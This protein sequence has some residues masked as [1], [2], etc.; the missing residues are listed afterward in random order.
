MKH[1]LDLVLRAHTTPHMENQHLA[2]HAQQA[3]SARQEPLHQQS[4]QQAAFADQVLQ[5][6]LVLSALP[7]S[8]Q[9][10]SQ[11]QRHQNV[12]IVQKVTIAQAQMLHLLCSQFPVLQAN[13]LS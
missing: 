7:A 1:L 5:I 4:V 13:T 8:T 12:G 3:T 9:A 10:Q 6:M 2:P 11:F